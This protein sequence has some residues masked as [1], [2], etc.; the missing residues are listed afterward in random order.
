M[1]EIN[2]DKSSPPI[3][4]TG[5]LLVHRHDSKQ[6]ACYILQIEALRYS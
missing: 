3:G 4:S 2:P 6:T 5:S 1:A